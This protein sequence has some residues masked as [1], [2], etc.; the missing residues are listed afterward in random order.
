MSEDKPFYVY[1]HRRATDGRVFY[2]GKGKGKRSEDISNRNLYWHNIVNKHGFTAHIIIR[3]KQEECAFSFERALIKHYGRDNLCNLTDG[4]D[5]ACGAKR[6]QETIEKIKIARSRQESPNKGKK[7]S[8]SHKNA[9]SRAKTGTK[10][11]DDQ[12]ND[13]SKRTKGNL[14]PFFGKSHS[15]ETRKI[16]SDIASSRIVTDE[17][18]DKLKASRRKRFGYMAPNIS[19]HVFTF[20]HDG[21]MVFT[22]TQYEFYTSNNLAQGNISA[23]VRGKVKSCKGWR[24]S[25]DAS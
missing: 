18:K 11:S 6:S 19:K 8:E 12:R 9:I 15:V 25:N 2:V 21:G 13:I 16:L 10:M 14:N 17:T 23:L 7:L 24:L 22:G 4:G 20:V 3:F 5:G 1:V